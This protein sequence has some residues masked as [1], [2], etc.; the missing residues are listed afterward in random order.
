MLNSP[1]LNSKIINFSSQTTS[2]AKS[3]TDKKKSATCADYRIFSIAFSGMNHIN[4]ISTFTIKTMIGAINFPK[5]N[6]KRANPID[7]YDLG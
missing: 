6:A 3:I 1:T 7:K 5:I 2:P 4:R